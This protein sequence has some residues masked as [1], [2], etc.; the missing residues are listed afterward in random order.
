VLHWRHFGCCEGIPRHWRRFQP[1]IGVKEM[2]RPF[3]SGEVRISL[4]AFRI[5]LFPA[6]EAKNEIHFHEL[7]RKTGERIH[8]EKVSG[9]SA[10]VKHDD[11]AKGYEYSK[12]EY[13]MIEPAEIENLRIPSRQTLEV[14]QFVSLKDVD[15]KFFEKPYFVAPE[16]PS[17][18]EAFAV[19][20]KA[21]QSTGK[22]A[23][24]K[25]AYG[26]R[27]H[28]VAI[29]APEDEKQAGMMAY[30]MRYAEELRDPA[31][32][33]GD[34][35]PVAIDEDQLS[36]AK[37]L[38]QRKSAAFVPDKYTDDYEIGLRALIDAKV[39][40]APLP[41]GEPVAK[42]PKVVNLMD[43]LRRSVSG[44][45][46]APKKQAP[47]SGSKTGKKITL[48]SPKKEAARPTKAASK[49]RSA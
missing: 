39:K 9:D 45:D 21:M 16:D 17:H 28:L 8:H 20:R 41:K 13:V 44:D 7:D 27:E 22:V 29:A 37:E 32:Y 1:L 42:S 40:H 26:G 48:V 38:I 15:P 35:K 6:T 14:T 33:F 47:A 23:I 5:R 24:G 18:A 30:T 36:L 4:V 3:W 49:R 25:I 31:D 12:G 10:P 43:A 11:I 34:I 19:V 46:S 2:A